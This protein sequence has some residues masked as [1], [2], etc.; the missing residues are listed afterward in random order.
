M[1][2]IQS[3][4]QSTP[5]CFPLHDGTTEISCVCKYFNQID[6]ATVLQLVESMDYGRPVRKSI[7][8]HGQKS[9]PNPKEEHFVCHIS[10][11]FQ[12][13]LIYAFIGCPQ[14]VVERIAEGRNFHRTVVRRCN[15]KP[16]KTKCSQNLK[17]FSNVGKPLQ[18]VIMKPKIFTVCC[19]NLLHFC[20]KCSIG[21]LQCH[22][23][24]L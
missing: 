17:I 23:C 21:Y 19:S 6:W 13:S 7:S 18:M 20:Y 3:V 12:I 5:S 22:M 14:S 10:P 15:G 2:L 16:E 11:N 4:F 1:K 24:L 8:L 9:N